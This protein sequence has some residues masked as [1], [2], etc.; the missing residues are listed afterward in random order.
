MAV[1]ATDVGCLGSGRIQDASARVAV[2]YVGK[3]VEMAET[4]ALFIHPLHPYTE[5]LMSAVPKPDPR[6]RSRRIVLEGEVAD[7]SNPPSGC[8]FHPRC[9]YMQDVCKAKG[10]EMRELRPGHFVSCHRAEEL[11]LLGVG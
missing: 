10:P 2:M 11:Q 8:Y 3:L 4:E 5:A 1:V 9:R 7:P 6:C